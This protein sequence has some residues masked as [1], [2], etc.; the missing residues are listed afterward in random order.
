MSSKTPYEI[1]AE[2]LT[3]AQGIV[4]ERHYVQNDKRQRDWEKECETISFLMHT[5]NSEIGFPK[6][7]EVTTASVDEVISAAKQLNEFVTNG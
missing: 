6:S 7:P 3:L 2:I 1:R 4:A 5:T